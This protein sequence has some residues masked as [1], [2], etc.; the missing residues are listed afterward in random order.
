MAAAV[1]EGLDRMLALAFRTFLHDP[2]RRSAAMAGLGAI[3]GAI[4]LLVHGTLKIPA[5]ATETLFV[6]VHPAH[7]CIGAMTMMRVLVREGRV[8]P[9]G[10]AAISYLLSIAIVTIADSLLPFLGE[11]LL[12]LPSRH[13]HVGFVE[14]WWV[15]HPMAVAG[16][17]LA[18]GAPRLRLH[19]LLVLAASAL[20]PLYDMMMAMWKALDPVAIVTIPLFAALSVWT[21]LVGTAVVLAG[22]AHGTGAGSARGRVIGLYLNAVQGSD[23]R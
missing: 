8:P 14:I 17:A 11:L 19:P 22:V 10:A 16:I 6:L 12:S 5:A 1:I 15:V 9:I 7:V 21:Y 4:V 20:P 23:G 13:V 2:W 18:L 3:I